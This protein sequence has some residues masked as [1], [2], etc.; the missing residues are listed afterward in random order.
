MKLWHGKASAVASQAVSKPKAPELSRSSGQDARDGEKETPVVLL[1]TRAPVGTAGYARFQFPEED[2]GMQT[3]IIIHED[4]EHIQKLPATLDIQERSVFFEEQGVGLLAVMFRIG[5]ERYETWWNHHNPISRQSFDD[6][7]HRPL[8]FFMFLDDTIEPSRVI[9][10]PNRLQTV[11][12]AFA[13][14]V[15]R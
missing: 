7:Q 10:T 8:L 2:G 1:V 11:F 14:R 6:L 9:W 15:A 12:A 4:T 3:A 13:G 5:S